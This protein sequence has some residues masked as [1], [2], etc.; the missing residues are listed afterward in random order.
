LLL[1]RVVDDRLARCEQAL[2]IGVAGRVRQV[3]D[4]VL[5][6]LVGRLEAERGDVADV[7]LDDVLALFLHLPGLLEHRPRM[8]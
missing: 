8:S 5:H 7:Q 6:D 2:R 3:A 1:L 4:H